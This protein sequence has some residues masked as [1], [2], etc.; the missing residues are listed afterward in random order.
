MVSLHESAYHLFRAGQLEQSLAATLEALASDG[1]NGRLWEL[2]GFVHAQRLEWHQGQYAL[3][4]ASVFVPLSPAGRVCLAECYRQT[5]RAQLACDLAVA[6]AEEQSLPLALTLALA[7][8]LDRVSYTSTAAQLCRRAVSSEPAWAQAWFD[9]AYYL[10]RTEPDNPTI[11][12]AA[13]RALQLDPGK[14]SF[15]LGLACRLACADRLHEAYELVRELDNN[16]IRAVCCGRCLQKLERIYSA[17]GDWQRAEFCAT[18]RTHK[19]GC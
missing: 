9:L 7:A 18:L 8:L 16:A 3:E 12:F 17:T 19:A 6:M 5:G 11:D 10:A 13:R 14:L 1:E 4:T 2:R 15:R